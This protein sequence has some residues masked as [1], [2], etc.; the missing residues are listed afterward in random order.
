MRQEFKSQRQ[1][2]NGGDG[3]GRSS[4]GYCG[5]VARCCRRRRTTVDVISVIFKV[6][7]VEELMRVNRS[8]YSRDECTSAVYEYGDLR[9]LVDTEELY[10]V[11]KEGSYT[12]TP[13]SH[14]KQ[15]EGAGSTL[16]LPPPPLNRY[17]SF[18]PSVE[19]RQEVEQTLQTGSMSEQT[20]CEYLWFFAEV[21]VDRPPRP[22][23]LRGDSW[24]AR[25][26]RT[27]ISVREA[28]EA[29]C[30]CG[31]G[32]FQISVSSDTFWNLLIY[33]NLFI[34]VFRIRMPDGEDV[35]HPDY[36]NSGGEVARS[37]DDFLTMILLLFALE[38]SLKIVAYGFCHFW[39]NGYNR[40]DF[41]VTVCAAVLQVALWCEI[42]IPRE[43]R[44]TLLV[45]RN[46]RILSVLST[47]DP[48]YRIIMSSFTKG[49]RSVREYVVIIAVLYY[50]YAVLG[51]NLFAGVIP[52]S[53]EDL[54]K[55][56][57]CANTALDPQRAKVFD[58]L[59]LGSGDIEWR[60]YDKDWSCLASVNV[61]AATTTSR[62]YANGTETLQSLAML[63]D[64]ACRHSGCTNYL[65][66]N[67]TAFSSLHYWDLNFN[68]FRS[69]LYVLFVLMMVNNWVVV[70]EGYISVMGVWIRLYFV[71]WYM[72]VVML[73]LNIVTAF[74]LQIF[75]SMI[76]K[77][78]ETEGTRRSGTDDGESIG[79][80]AESEPA[81]AGAGADA[82]GADAAGADAAGADAA[83]ADAKTNAPSK[84]VSSPSKRISVM[85][86]KK[87]SKREERW[88]GMFRMAGRELGYQDA[89]EWRLLRQEH[90][91]DKMLMLEQGASD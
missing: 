78:T 37:L 40:L 49:V 87:E 38:I 62:F 30:L 9:E 56:C 64:C 75:N 67:Q 36:S 89:D 14:P 81:A 8:Q 46:L 59:D 74:F 47:L 35:G 11:G 6:L 24:T 43:A 33:A 68:D 86:R 52:G 84:R 34:V 54:N 1:D 13:I 44:Q 79:S 16:P 23:V 70:M 83:G 3:G 41:V 19:E 63:R 90:T 60:A 71:S 10:G 18:I 2:E 66:V 55:V 50:I 80:N 45:L 39:K 32:K 69:S 7:Q 21:K 72:V 61:A 53:R 5:W 31:R 58:R 65:A 76:G 15:D 88:M 4:R 28:L 29:K 73:V 20:F 26:N 57:P 51:M 22:P 48:I 12:T 85:R 91:Y 82:T 77:H 27:A 17:S 42:S 25:Y